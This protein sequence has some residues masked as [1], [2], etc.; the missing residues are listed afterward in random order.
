MLYTYQEGCSFQGLTVPS[1][2]EHAKQL[3]LS[4]IV[5]GGAKSHRYIDNQLGSFL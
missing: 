3:E 1:G 5:H 2:D 4:N